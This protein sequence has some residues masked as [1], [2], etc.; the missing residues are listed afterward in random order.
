MP[1]TSGDYIEGLGKLPRESFILPHRLVTASTT[2][3]ERVV[4]RLK[5]GKMDEVARKVFAILS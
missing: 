1:I 4:A 3:F 2:L 5:P